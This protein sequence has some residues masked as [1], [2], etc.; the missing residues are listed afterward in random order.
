MKINKDGTPRKVGSG[1]TKGATSFTN[2]TLA[3]LLEF[4]G[5]KTIIP[6]SRVWLENMGVETKAE[7][8]FVSS[9]QPTPEPEQKIEFVL[10]K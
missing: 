5:E 7:K 6:V 3:Q 9:I 4:C 1:R 10:H 8:V 2:I